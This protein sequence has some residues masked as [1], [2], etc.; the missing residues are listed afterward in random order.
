MLKLIRLAVC[1][2]AVAAVVPSAAGANGT[3]IPGHY[4]VVLKDGTSVSDAA[5]D[6][7]R[8]A[9]AK[10][11]QTYGSAIRGYAAKVSDIGLGRIKSDR[12]VDFVMQDREGTPIAAQSLP[13]GVNRIEADL[14]PAFTPAPEVP[15]TPGDVAIFDTGID[16]GHPDLDVAGGVNCVGNDPYHDGTSGDE[17]GHGTHVAGTVGAK[18]DDIGVVGV[19]PGVRLWSV[20]VLNR[21]GGGSASTQ[22]CGIDWITANA[23]TLGIKVVNS[24][25]ALFGKPDDNNC[26]N[27]AG[28]A[29]HRAICRSIAAGVT[30][31]FAAGNTAGDFKGVAGASYDEVLTATAMGDGNGQPNVP[32]SATFSCVP[33]GSRKGSSHTDDKYASFSKY[34]TVDANHTVAAPGAC[35]YSTWLGGSYAHANGTSMAAPHAAAVTHLC[36][37]GGHCTG[38][39]AQIIQKIR[40]D[41]AAA[42]TSNSRYGFTGDPLRPAKSSGKGATTMYFGHLVRADLY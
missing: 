36:V 38:T 20:R 4:I 17:H 6:H 27:T 1:L 15:A 3:P 24:S 35:V 2:C 42:T 12:R 33:V 22:L 13:A 18:N 30:W 34:A 7:R 16:P 31:V 26:G 21:Y 9:G 25:Q 39:P 5:A 28:D 32:T 14:R 11:L 23:A 10:V 37:V 40:S 29:L 41:A 19:A 8:D